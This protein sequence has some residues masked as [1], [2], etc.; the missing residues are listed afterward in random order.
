MDDVTL[1]ADLDPAARPVDGWYRLL[2][3]D[4]RLRRLLA[5]RCD[6]ALPVEESLTAVAQLWD[7]PLAA[8]GSMYAVHDGTGATVAVAAPQGGE[9]ERACQI[10]TPPFDEDHETRLE[11]LLSAAR[12]LAFA[13]PVESATH[14]HYDGA[15]FREPAALANVV[16]LFGLW[17]PALR[18]LLRTN[19]ACHRIQP[20]PRQLVDAAERKASLDSLREAATAAGL[21]KYFD[22]NITQL[23]A[24]D[25]IRDTLEVRILATD[26]CVEPIL[27]SAL[28]LERLLLRCLDPEPLPPAPQDPRRAADG[29]ST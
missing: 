13:V 27:R 10:V 26:L 2:T 1:V 3:D 24:D 25:P 20:L 5:A 7:V 6:P 16:R 23:L 8:Y 9:R 12:E 18:R 11:L 29:S 21:T 14:I 17:S 22:A 28:L 15:P 19:D 4:G